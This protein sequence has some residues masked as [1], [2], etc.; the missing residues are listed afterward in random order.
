MTIGTPLQA[1]GIAAACAIA[2]VT[3]FFN[4]HAYTALAFALGFVTFAVLAAWLSGQQVEPQTTPPTLN[5]VIRSTQRPYVMDLS[6]NGEDGDWLKRWFRVGVLSDKLVNVHVLLDSCVPESENVFP[7]H[8]LEV[9]GQQERTEYVDVHPG[10]EPSVFIDV[11]TQT[12]DERSGI[13][14]EDANTLRFCYVRPLRSLIPNQRQRVGLKVEGGGASRT[15]FFAIDFD[16]KGLAT[17]TP[18]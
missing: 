10:A 14:P 8:A 5:L 1:A 6:R 15:R 16:R 7:A 11:F 17:F 12:I 18:D 9:M 4:N 3:L 2:A 13:D